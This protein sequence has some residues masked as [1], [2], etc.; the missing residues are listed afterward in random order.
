MAPA[1]CA[2]SQ[3]T[4]A[5]TACAAA[6]S[7]FVAEQ[8]ASDAEVAP[9]SLE[10]IDETLAVAASAAVVEIAPCSLDAMS[11]CLEGMKRKAATGTPIKL[12]ITNGRAHGI[13]N[14][15]SKA[16]GTPTPTAALAATAEAHWQACKDMS[17]CAA[18]AYIG[19]KVYG[20]P[21]YL[22]F[23]REG[24]EAVDFFKAV[25]PAGRLEKVS[26][27]QMYDAP[28]R[29]NPVLMLKYVEEHQKLY[30]LVPSA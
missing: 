12:P 24:N 7:A 28:K 15:L 4:S 25:Q 2:R 17:A 3:I 22:V 26:P 1:E 6:V 29:D 8:A 23:V 5:P 27:M 11:F 30:A 13:A 10:A 20:C 19:Q 21:I 18:A 14:V 16:H 9:A